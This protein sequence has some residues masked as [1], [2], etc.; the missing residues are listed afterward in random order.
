MSSNK[1]QSK[2]VSAWNSL[3]ALAS[4]SKVPVQIK[5]P[6]SEQAINREISRISEI[7]HSNMFGH[8]N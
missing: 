1:R 5:W 6:S 8:L 3:K 7:A 4:E 2:N